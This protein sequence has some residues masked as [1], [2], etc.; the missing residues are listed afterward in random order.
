MEWKDYL[1]EFFINFKNYYKIWWYIKFKSG[2]N[3]FK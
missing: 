3:P 2:Y 1:M